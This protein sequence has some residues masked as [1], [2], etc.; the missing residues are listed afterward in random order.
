[1]ATVD[2][3][4]AQEAGASGSLSRFL[5]RLLM[6]RATVTANEALGDRFR[7]VTLE[8][9][10]LRDMAWTPGQKIQIAM[11]SAFAAR[12]YTPLT[13]NAVEGRTCILGYAHGVGPGSDWLRAAVP[14][15]SCDIFGPRASLNMARP[16]GPL[17][18]FGDETS[19]GLAYALGQR[20]EPAEAVT[21]VLEV[22]DIETS[23]S[24]AA[25]LQL[26]GCTLISRQ[27]EGV[28]LS[29]FES[30]LPALADTGAT[31]ILTGRAGSI[32][33]ARR[34]LKTLLV[35]SK[36]IRTKAHWTPGK[37]GLD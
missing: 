1:M 18:I 7:L 15:S 26:Q 4:V 22:G 27:P 24:V 9:P 30:K 3:A 35:P 20:D 32:Q 28:H 2:K 21:A 33:R 13:W 16:G 19:F 37:T 12:T 11:G 10:G 23:R 34:T 5:I 31:F 6:K 8:G 25:Q 17:A 36:R 29:E 14:G